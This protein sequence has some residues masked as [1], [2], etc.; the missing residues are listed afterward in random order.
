[1]VRLASR[2]GFTWVSLAKRLC[3]I[4]GVVDPEGPADEA[5][6]VE[7]VVAV[8]PQVEVVEAAVAEVAEAAVAVAVARV[9]VGRFRLQLRLRRQ[10]L[11]QRL[12]PPVTSRAK[13]QVAS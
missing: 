8:V 2:Y 3:P 11:L 5:V 7:A 1:M 9:E 13:M 10:R 6:A 4:R 12:R